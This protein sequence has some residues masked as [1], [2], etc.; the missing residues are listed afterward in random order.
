MISILERKWWV[1]ALVFVPSLIV[2]GP[3]LGLYLLWR[4]PAFLRAV[5]SEPGKRGRSRAARGQCRSIKTGRHAPREAFSPSIPHGPGAPN[6]E[7]SPAPNKKPREPEQG[8]RGFL[9]H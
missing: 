4:L 9:R 2:G 7:V 3:M 8:P 1:G 6:N 5:R